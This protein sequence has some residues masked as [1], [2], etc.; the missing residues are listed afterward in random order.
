[1]ETRTM[2]VHPLQAFKNEFY[3]FKMVYLDL[4][5]F[6]HEKTSE[7][8]HILMSFIN[9]MVIDIFSDKTV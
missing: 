7:E 4:E 2:L 5:M 8:N 9:D 3:H 6:V 1:M